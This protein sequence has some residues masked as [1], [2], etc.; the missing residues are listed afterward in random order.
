MEMGPI[1]R[2]KL[3]DREQMGRYRAA[4][5]AT[6]PFCPQNPLNSGLRRSAKERMPSPASAVETVSS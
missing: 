2:R 5:A 1:K 4:N 3:T 6:N